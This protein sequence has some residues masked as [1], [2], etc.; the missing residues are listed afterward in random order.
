[1]L[2]GIVP[3][4]NGVFP[5]VAGTILRV[6]GI[7]GAVMGF[8]CSIRACTAGG[9]ELLFGV[10]ETLATLA[11]FLLAPRAFFRAGAEVLPG[12]TYSL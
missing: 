9:W 12:R 7:N 4:F 3:D 8:L 10:R 6:R 5:G 1:M 11:E 2:R